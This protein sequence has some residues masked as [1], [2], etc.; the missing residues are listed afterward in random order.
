MSRPLWRDVRALLSWKVRLEGGAFALERA[1]E[2]FNLSC[3]ASEMVSWLFLMA[4]S[5][6][7]IRLIQISGI[8]KKIS[9]TKRR[10]LT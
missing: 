1:A 7:V 9:F 6:A 5:V 8:L 2:T 10:F 3:S 4:D